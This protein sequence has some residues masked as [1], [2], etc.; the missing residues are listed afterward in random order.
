MVASGIIWQAHPRAL[1]RSRVREAATTHGR[2][3][4][5]PADDRVGHSVRDRSV[6]PRERLVG[7]L[8]RGAVQCLP[9]PVELA[10][11]GRSSVFVD[12]K[13]A[14]AAWRDLRVAGEAIAEAL[15]RAG[16]RFDAVGGPTLGADAVAVAVAAVSDTQWFVVRSQPKQRGTRRLIEGARL[17]PDTEAVLV[18]D[19][20][21]TGRSLVGAWKAVTGTGARVVA[22]S[23]VVDRGDIAKHRLAGLGIGYYPMVTYQDLGIDPVS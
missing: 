20:T 23:V 10:S 19:V 9:E 5:L 16:V 18:D 2:C 15:T 17:G 7:T 12:I 11:G 22:A 1:P 8:R 21:T 13:A 6:R 14:L 4:A 3:V